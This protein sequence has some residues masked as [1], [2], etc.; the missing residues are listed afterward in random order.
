MLSCSD[1]YYDLTDDF[2]LIVSSFFSEYGY[3]IYSDDF[4]N[5]TWEE[6]SAMLRGLGAET[7]LVRIVRIR[8]EKDGDVLRHFTKE[9]HRIRNDWIKKKRYRGRSDTGTIEERD[10]LLKQLADTFRKGR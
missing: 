5:M 6:F 10:R 3:R 9:Q 1:P 2:D 7:P 4:K 8:S